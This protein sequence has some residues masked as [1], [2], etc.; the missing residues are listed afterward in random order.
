RRDCSSNI[1]VGPVALNLFKQLP[2]ILKDDFFFVRARTISEK[3]FLAQFHGS[4]FHTICIEPLLYRTQKLISVYLTF[5]RAPCVTDR[6]RIELIKRYSR[7]P[8]EPRD[9]IRNQPVL[10]KENQIVRVHAIVQQ[11]DYRFTLRLSQ[12]VLRRFFFT[13]QF[14]D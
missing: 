13:E 1:T 9:R 7:V 2:Q 5:P 11:I 8:T 12:A 3:K 10:R 4:S 6:S 14:S